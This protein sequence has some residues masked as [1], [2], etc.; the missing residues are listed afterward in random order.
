MLLLLDL[1]V[2]DDLTQVVARHSEGVAVPVAELSPA[3]LGVCHTLVIHV[4]DLE[5]ERGRQSM[6]VCAW[7][8]EV[9]PWYGLRGYL[10]T[11][12]LWG[13]GQ[14]PHSNQRVLSSRKKLGAQTH[15]Q[16]ETDR[17]GKLSISIRIH[18][19]ALRCFAFLHGSLVA[20]FKIS[21]HTTG[22]KH[23]PLSGDR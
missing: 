15:R 1:C 10:H 20:C 22:D 2:A 5:G 14:M 6:S 3:D 23:S 18:S 11:V 8:R 17:H 13:H 21:L 12:S 9:P 19:L 4:H 7:C 16:T